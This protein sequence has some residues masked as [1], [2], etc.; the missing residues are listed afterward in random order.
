MLLVDA[1]EDIAWNILTFNRDY[2]WSAA[3]IRQREANSETPSHNGNTLLGKENWLQGQVG[4]IFATL[5]AAPVK[6][7]LGGWDTQAYND[8]KEAHQHL[9]AQLD[10]Y[11]KLVDQD[12]QFRLID[13]ESTLNTVLHTWTDPQADAEDRLIG[14]VALMEGADAIR[15]PEEVYEWYERGLRIIGLA[16]SGSRY[17]GGTQQPGPITSEGFELMESMLDLGMLLDLSHLSEEAYFQAVERYEGQIIASHSNPRRFLPTVRG[18]S[19]EMIQLLA[20]R[21]GVVGI[22][23]YNRFL[24]PGW[25]NGDPREQ[26]ALDEVAAAIDHVCQI[27]GNAYHVGIGTDFDGG[28]GLESVPDGIVT[29]SDIQKLIPLLKERGYDDS[30]IADIFA[31]NWIR[32]L[33]TGLPD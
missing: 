20:E 28:F 27:T 5:F 31:N 2:R 22:V 11:H 33:R 4:I 3:E 12:S 19:D 24:K 8:T 15:A 14:L 10:V 13:V 26:V 9:S 25:Q 7:A 21:D 30:Q 1:H 32:M 29:I 6:F 17:A 23:P 16:W 18:L